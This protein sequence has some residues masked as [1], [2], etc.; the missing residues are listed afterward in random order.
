M[1]QGILILLIIVGEHAII[2]VKKVM[3]QQIVHKSGRGRA[4]SVGVWN[5]MLKT[6]QRFVMLVICSFSNRDCLNM[7]LEFGKAEL[8]LKRFVGNTSS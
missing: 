3:Q 5:I 7:L 2:V 8:V 1:A 4:L 6:A